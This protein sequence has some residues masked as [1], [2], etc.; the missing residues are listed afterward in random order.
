MKP[1]LRYKARPR[2]WFILSP[3]HSLFTSNCY[4]INNSIKCRIYL[5]LALPPLLNDHRAPHG[6]PKGLLSTHH[7]P[8]PPSRPTPPQTTH[9]HLPTHYKPLQRLLEHIIKL[10]IENQSVI[11]VENPF[12][13]L[14][15]ISTWNYPTFNQ[16]PMELPHPDRPLT[17]PLHTLTNTLSLQPLD[18]M[19]YYPIPLFMSLGM[20]I[21]SGHPRWSMLQELVYRMWIRR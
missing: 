20:R 9:Q 5:V 18:R 14:R 13:S 7:H 6:L 8:P 10:V 11:S 19:F 3:T 21:H 4:D 17:D 16:V 2:V 15:T 1:K 12:P